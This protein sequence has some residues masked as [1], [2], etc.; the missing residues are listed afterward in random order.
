MLFWD[1]FSASVENCFLL[2]NIQRPASF[3]AHLISVSTQIKSYRKKITAVIFPATIPPSPLKQGHTASSDPSLS[4]GGL[5]RSRDL[6]VYPVAGQRGRDERA[7]PA[8]VPA[9]AQHVTQVTKEPQV[10]GP[11]RREP[12]PCGLTAKQQEEVEEEERGHQQETH[13]AR[14][15]DE[16]ECEGAC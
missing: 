2:C 12:L 13:H 16:G 10:V 15:S 4:L 14:V 6:E 8:E 5:Q 9:E 11:A 3:S 7:E 1:I